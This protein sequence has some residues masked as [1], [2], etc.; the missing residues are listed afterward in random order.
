MRWAFFDL[1]RSV[2]VDAFALEVYIQNVEVL[3]IVKDDKVIARGYNH[4]ESKNDVSSH[5]EMEAIRKANKKL[6]SWRLVDCDIYITLEPCLMCT[7]A[8]IQSRIR[9]IYL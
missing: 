3:H 6:N 4:R 5:A 8:I 2:F 9:N 1:D 7:G